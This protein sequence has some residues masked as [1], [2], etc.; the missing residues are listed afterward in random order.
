MVSCCCSSNGTGCLF[1][2]DPFLVPYCLRG[3]TDAVPAYSPDLQR[4]QCET[5]L[6]LNNFSLGYRATRV[7]RDNIFHEILSQPLP[8]EINVVSVPGSSRST[9]DRNLMEQSNFREDCY[10]IG[11]R[12]G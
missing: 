4:R 12:G 11:F 8:V 5:I 9:L 3:E 7:Y 1:S 6:F 2:S 10:T